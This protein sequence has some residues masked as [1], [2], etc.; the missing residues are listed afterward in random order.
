MTVLQ[1]QVAVIR[2]NGSA[3]QPAPSGTTVFPHDEIRTLNDT[4]ALITFFS[5]TEIELGE[6][7]ILVVERVSREGDSV[8][9]SLVQVF[10]PTVNRVASLADSGSSYRIQ[11][12]GGVA[13]VRGTSF[14]LGVM[15]PFAALGCATGSVE[16]DIVS[17]EPG[18][19]LVWE[20]D[21][22]TATRTSA[23]QEKSIPEGNL[24]AALDAVVSA[25]AE[26]ANRPGLSS[27]ATENE[28]GAAAN[29]GNTPPGGS[30]CSGGDGEKGNSEEAHATVAS[31]APRGTRRVHFSGSPR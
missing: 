29:K 24:G 8:H 3:I 4:G 18:P 2:S 7:T 6:D 19:L 10:G 31:R 1:G 5:G 30:G 20:F 22:A 25:I 26:L 16:M 21:Q 28:Q 14:A 9:V 23:F 17:C 11:A 13:V 12:G 15:A 27:G